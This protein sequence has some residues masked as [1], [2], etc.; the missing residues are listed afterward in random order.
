[1]NS[2]INLYGTWT[3][4]RVPLLRK[5]KNLIWHFD[6]P[7]SPSCTSHDVDKISGTFFIRIYDAEFRPTS[8]PT[9]S[10]MFRLQW[11]AL[12]NLGLRFDFQMLVGYLLHYFNIGFI[13]PT[14]VAQKLFYSLRNFCSLRVVMFDC[15]RLTSN[16]N[17]VTFRNINRMP[18]RL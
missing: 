6:L 16:L 5:I 14:L 13:L 10:P 7:P 3:I 8:P 17:I 18:E 9:S 4:R 1:M 11:T 15:S 12:I 2:L